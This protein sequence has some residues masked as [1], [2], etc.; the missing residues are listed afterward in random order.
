MAE[1]Y[2]FIS[3]ANLPT[4]DAKEVDVLCVEGGELKRKPGAS[5]GGGG[6]YVV[7]LPADTQM[8]MDESDGMIIFM[9]EESRDNF[10]EIL[11]NGGSVLIDVG[12]TSFGPEI[13]DGFMIINPIAWTVQEGVLTA[14]WML[15]EGA[16]N[17]IAFM[18]MF[19]NG[20]WTPPT[21]E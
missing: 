9:V 16:G 6:G 15:L 10:A 19:P 14:M 18:F 5:I 8:Q 21:A 4:T 3:A 20:T 7:R 11:Y 1:N 13:E 2:E 12:A 17:G